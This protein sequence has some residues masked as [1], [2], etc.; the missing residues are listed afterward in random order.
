VT[1]PPIALDILTGFLGAGKTTVL[2][3]LL[4]APELADA[5]VV[6]NEFGDVGIDHALVETSAEGIVELASGCLCCALRGDLVDTLTD[7][8]ARLDD[9]RIPRLSR[10]VIETSGL[11]DPAPILHTIMRHAGL[12]ARFR[13]DAVVTVVDAVNGAATLDAHAEAVKQAAVADRLVVTKTDLLDGPD[14]LAPL[15]GRLAALNPRAPM[16]DAGR[17][18]RVADL[19]DAGLWSADGRIP[20]VARWLDA[21][22]ADLAPGHVCGPACVHLD[23][24]RHGAAARPATTLAA[25]TLAAPAFSAPPALHDAAVRSFS[26]V[27]DTAVP[28]GALDLFLDLLRSAHGPRLLRLKGIVRLKE[29][30]DRPLVLHAVQHVLHPPVQLAA[31][32]DADHRTR[33]VFITRDLDE[34]FVRRMFGALVGEVA[35]DT[36]DR[37]ALDDNPLAISGFSGRFR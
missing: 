5:L 2:N 13:L 7:A 30:P 26:I 24:R 8:V 6:V 35:T 20:D 19:F 9:G 18:W 36:P 29:D 3:R 33:L 1:P 21:A 28:V 25:T 14:A 16:I 27:T 4:K 32:P 37:A 12:V 15:A 11:A 31:W 23:L 22:A 34:G 10:V 17:P